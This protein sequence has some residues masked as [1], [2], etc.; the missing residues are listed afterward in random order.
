MK[1]GIRIWF[2]IGSGIALLLWLTLLLS[3]CG[4]KGESAKASEEAFTRSGVREV[5][6]SDSD[7]PDRLKIDLDSSYMRNA[8]QVEKSYFSIVCVFVDV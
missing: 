4:G 1:R 6:F 2:R 8:L 3:G 5:F 7:H